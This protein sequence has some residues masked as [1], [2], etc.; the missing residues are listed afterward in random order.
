[1]SGGLQVLDEQGRVKVDLS[2][3][4]TRVLGKMTLTGD[5]EFNIE[6]YPNLDPWCIIYPVIS[7][8]P[9]VVPLVRRTGRKII[10]RNQGAS[11][12]LVVYGVC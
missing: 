1:M 3:R 11:G 6:G 7:T 4:F 12:S 10:W 2:K 9:G 8:S 5:G